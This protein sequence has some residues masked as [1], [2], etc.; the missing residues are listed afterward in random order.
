MDQTEQHGV[1]QKLHR[2]IQRNKPK[3]RYLHLIAEEC[4][5]HHIHHIS[6]VA[7]EHDAPEQCGQPAP[8]KQLQ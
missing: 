4:P 8:E 2:V 6:E 7:S 5:G 3:S 1:D